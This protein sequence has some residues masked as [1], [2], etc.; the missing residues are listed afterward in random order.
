MRPDTYPVEVDW[1]LFDGAMTKYV[2]A[3]TL[4]EEERAELEG[5]KE[6]RPYDYR[7]CKRRALDERANPRVRVEVGELVRVSPGGK[8]GWYK[9]NVGVIRK[10]LTV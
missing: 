3:E 2:A 7:T 10:P 9:T 1:K 6:M 5:V 4:T 8:H